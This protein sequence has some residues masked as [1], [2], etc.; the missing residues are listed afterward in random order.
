MSALA[1]ATRPADQTTG[2]LDLVEAVRAGDDRAFEL[3]FLRYQGRIAAYVHG[4]VRDHGRAEDITQEVFL[5]A[6]RRMRATD[7][8]IVFEPWVYEIAKNACID[9]YRRGRVANEVS[10]DAEESLGTSDCGRLAASGAAPEAVID[11]KLALDNLCASFGGLSQAHH[12]ILVMREFEGLSYREIGDRLGMSQAA[13]ESTLFRARRRLTEE[14]EELV[15]GARCLLVQ[16][17]VDAPRE[18]AIGLRDRRRMARHLAHCQPCRR[19]AHLAGADL[20]NLRGRA[21]VGARIAALLPL[22]AFL[23][24]RVD[25]DAT[26]IAT[27]HAGPATQWTASVATLDPATLSGWSKAVATAATVAVASLGAGAAVKGPDAVVEFVSKAP[28]AVGL[29]SPDRPAGAAPASKRWTPLPEDAARLPAGPKVAGRDGAPAPAGTP[30]TGDAPAG[31]SV[32]GEPARQPDGSAPAGGLLPGV[33][34]AVGDTPPLAGAPAPDASAPGGDRPALRPRDGAGDGP[35]RRLL[36][37]GA[38]QNVTTASPQTGLQDVVG[39]IVSGLHDVVST[40]TSG[41]ATSQDSGDEG[42]TEATEAAT[43]ETAAG[44]SPTPVSDLLASVAGGRSSGSG[45]EGT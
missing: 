23:R 4:R 37:G 45:A 12:D 16:D 3:L 1:V 13:V 2:D 38:S 6:L 44:T 32:P 35:V 5:A 36:D 20:E 30:A 22:P 15:S 19:Y 29:T 21:S 8:E 9:A 17:L 33:S 42:G 25:V 27:V 7:R 39:G 26:P 41:G 43:D 31:A 24:R 18:R 10:F 14:Y 34:S 40:V 28:A 11:T